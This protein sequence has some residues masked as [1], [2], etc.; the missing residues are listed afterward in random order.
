M[1]GRG[2]WS[3]L[4]RAGVVL[5]SLLLLVG[6]AD[7]TGDVD[8]APVAAYVVALSLLAVVLWSLRR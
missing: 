6:V 3:R 5:A 8:V 2:G 4:E 1:V 7:L